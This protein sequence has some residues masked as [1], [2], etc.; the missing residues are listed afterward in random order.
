MIAIAPLTEGTTPGNSERVW[1]LGAHVPE[2]DGFRGLA[3]LLVTLYRFAKDLPTDNF[4]G[5]SLHLA[6]NLGGRGVELFFVLSGFLITGILL[7][8]KGQPQY[9]R[10]FIA[11]RSL[12]IFPLYF[13]SL[14]LLLVGT[15]F[16]PAFKGMFA[17]GID[18]QFYLWTYLV[19]VKM[20]IANQWCFGYLDHFW[21]LAVEEHFYLVWPLILY[22]VSSKLAL[23]TAIGLAF[24][25]AILRCTFVFLT[26]NDV[27]PDVLT[28]FRCD[29]LLVG[30]AIAILART[31]SGLEPLRKW[32]APIAGGCALVVVCSAVM[33]KRLF[34]LP[35]SLWPMLWACVLVWLLTATRSDRLAQGFNLRWLRTLGKYSYAMYVFQNPLIPLTSGVISVAALTPLVGNG[36]ASHLL[37]V[38][39]MF[40]M[41]YAAAVL[42]WHLL[43]RHCLKLK[44]YFPTR[45]RLEALPKKPL[46]SGDFS[47]EESVGLS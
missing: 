41:T 7:D 31:S 29:A 40:V 34:T 43:E 2:L 42:S 15:T 26:T 8:G 28:I 35:L 4:L 12:R 9:F 17:Q 10:N 37:Y 6:F 25:S 20:S 27:A 23:R 14:L 38:C 5:Q 24:A 46:K 21:S 16:I 3:I 44:D 13:G 22:C 33:E 39:L 45:Q 47:Y 11:R 30:A 1:R 18:N 19:N 32:L 36:L